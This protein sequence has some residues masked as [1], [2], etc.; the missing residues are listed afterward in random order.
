MNEPLAKL[1]TLNH[2]EPMKRAIALALSARGKGNKPF[3]ALLADF[4]GT[5]LL[6]AENTL[7]L[8]TMTLP[9]TPKSTC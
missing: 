6:E 1:A 2:E 5:V 8:P 3:G 4:D 9:A 7:N